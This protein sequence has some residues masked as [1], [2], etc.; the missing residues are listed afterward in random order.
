MHR[1]AKAGA[2]VMLAAGTTVAA[3]GLVYEAQGNIYEVETVSGLL[4]NLRPTVES[5][6]WFGDEILARALANEVGIS[7]GVLNSAGLYGP[8]FATYVYDGVLADYTAG[9]VYYPLRQGLPEDDRA[10]RMNFS[11]SN[12]WTF[13]IGRLVGP[14]PATV[15]EP[16][17]LAVVALAAMLLAR[18]IK[19]RDD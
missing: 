18:R 16:P 9:W 12:T 7:L 10:Q 2:A 8:M 6:P 15:P 19:R 17:H 4:S 1:I 11:Y 14:A 13:A 3:A 5:Q